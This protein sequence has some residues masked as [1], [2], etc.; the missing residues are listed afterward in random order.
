MIQPRG[1][2]KIHGTN[3]HN[4]PCI[5][6]Q[7]HGVNLQGIIRVISG[8]I[9]RSTNR[10]EAELGEANFPNYSKYKLKSDKLYETLEHFE[11][12]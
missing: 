12:L 10:K 3:H 2:G 9:F 5:F 11:I 7:T 4:Q 1:F 6:C 8:Q